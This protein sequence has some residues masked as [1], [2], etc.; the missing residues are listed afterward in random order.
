MSDTPI[1]SPAPAPDEA[2]PWWCSRTL[3]INGLTL[4]LAAAEAHFGLLQGLLPG[5]VYQWIAFALP[6]VNAALRFITTQGVKL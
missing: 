2:K 5:T 3:W 1:T 4:A 6:V